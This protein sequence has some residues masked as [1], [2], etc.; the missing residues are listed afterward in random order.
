MNSR[1]FS[2]CDLYNTAKH[3]VVGN[4][5]IIIKAIKHPSEKPVML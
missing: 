3:P 5:L 2:S 4:K 1:E